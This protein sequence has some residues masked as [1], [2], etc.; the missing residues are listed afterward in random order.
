LGK[1]PGR[2]DIGNP[3]ARH[4]VAVSPTSAPAGSVPGPRSGQE[5]SQQYLCSLVR[6]AYSVPLD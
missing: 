6:L 1:T 3:H 5:E 4:D 2:E